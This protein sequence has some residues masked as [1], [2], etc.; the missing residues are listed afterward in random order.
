M[1]VV[2]LS[3]LVHWVVHGKLSGNYSNMEVGF[4]V[5]SDC[6]TFERFFVCAIWNL[7]GGGKEINAQWCAR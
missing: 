1:K 3:H 7:G 2:V 6:G 4:C 5:V